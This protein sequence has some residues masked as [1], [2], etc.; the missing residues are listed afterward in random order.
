[1]GKLSLNQS[2]WIIIKKLSFAPSARKSDTS[3]ATLYIKSSLKGHNV[4][5][6]KLISDIKK[7]VKDIK[8]EGRTEVIY[9][10]EP[11]LTII[12]PE[13]YRYELVQKIAN[14]A[15]KVAKS[16]GDDYRVTV[17]GLQ[18]KLLWER[19]GIDEMRLFIIYRY[20][21]VPKSSPILSKN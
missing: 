20:Q 13:K 8:L 5:S 15:S 11:I 4:K 10:K 17:Q 6:D 2:Q 19:A 18:Q 1:M 14:D 9:K 16:F 7:F 12:N 3:Y 21:I